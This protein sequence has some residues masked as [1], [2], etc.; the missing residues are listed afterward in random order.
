MDLKTG[1][2]VSASC[3]LF[4]PLISSLLKGQVSSFIVLG[5]V[6]WLYALLSGNEKLAGFSLAMMTT[7]PHIALI[8]AAPFLFKYRKV[9]LWFCVGSLFLLLY[10]YV[11]IGS[12][13]VKDYY[14]LVLLTAEG[15]AYGINQAS[16]YNF[17][18]LMLRLFPHVEA[19]LIQTIAWIVYIGAMIFLC[20]LWYR[21]R[22]I[23]ARLI[24]TAV[25]LAT[26]AAPHLHVHD[27]SLLIVPLL[28]VIIENGIKGKDG[29]FKT[30]LI[31]SFSSVVLILLSATSLRYTSVYVFAGIVALLLW[32]PVIQNRFA[33]K[34]HQ[35]S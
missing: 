4:F 11:L 27:L 13:G 9:W 8:L 24:G 16:M 25:L 21:S 31:I 14:G 22:E 10:S 12:Q 30:G 20:A 6:V 28:C 34:L 23:N 2:L 7:K 35:A 17:L 5:V 3:T 26:F 15:S 29:F 32:Y 33:L 1:L 18:G 19:G